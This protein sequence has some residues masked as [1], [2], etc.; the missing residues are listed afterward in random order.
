VTNH[1]KIPDGPGIFYRVNAFIKQIG[2][3]FSGFVLGVSRVLFDD[4]SV[5]TPGADRGEGRVQS[6]IFLDF[7]SSGWTSERDFPH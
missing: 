5:S 4:E 1:V 3:G 7:I 6:A 2:E